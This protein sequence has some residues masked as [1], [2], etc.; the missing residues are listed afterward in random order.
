MKRILGVDV[1]L[2]VAPTL[3]SWCDWYFTLTGHDVMN[4]IK[5]ETYNLENLMHAHHSPLDYWKKHDLYDNLIPIEN[6]KEVLLELSKSFDIVF[7]S[8]CVPEH[9]RS[10]EFFLKRNFP[11]H[12][13]F[14]DTSKKG[15]VKLD[16]FI[17]DYKK[18]LDQVSSSN[19]NC[20]CIMFKSDL[21]KNE[22]SYKRMDWKEIGEYLK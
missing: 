5:E 18:Y 20:D 15:L 8:S 22:N 13:G 19:P 21:N 6:S 7:V 9:I 17:D 3:K 4:D 14:V 10:K 11:F 2:T 1:D 12:K 16:I